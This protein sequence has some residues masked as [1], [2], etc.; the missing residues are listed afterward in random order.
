MPWW[1]REIVQ[2]RSLVASAVP[3]VLTSD[4]AALADGLRAEQIRGFLEVES[5]DAAAEVRV[6]RLGGG[7][8]EALEELDATPYLAVSAA[9]MSPVEWP[10]PPPPYLRTR[11]ELVRTSGAGQVNAVVRLVQTCRRDR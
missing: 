2:R 10:E 1:N 6:F 9:S 7:S 5:V 4:P 11:I 8:S 3:A